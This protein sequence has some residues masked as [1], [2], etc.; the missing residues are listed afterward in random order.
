VFENKVLW[1]TYGPEREGITGRWRKIHDEELHN[2]YCSPYIRFIKSK[3][4]RLEGHVEN[5]G[6]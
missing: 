2:L 1:R 3:R 4:K 6:R 5:M